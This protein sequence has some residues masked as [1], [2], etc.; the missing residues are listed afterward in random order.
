[1]RVAVAATSVGV[2]TGTDGRVPVGSAALTRLA[3]LTGW[4]ILTGGG[5]AGG[6]FSASQAMIEKRVSVRMAAMRRNVDRRG[7]WCDITGVA[8]LNAA[9]PDAHPGAPPPS[10]HSG[11]LVP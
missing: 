6:S 1:M 5:D 11:D 4:A 10:L 8:G 2:S 3:I 7:T 9:R